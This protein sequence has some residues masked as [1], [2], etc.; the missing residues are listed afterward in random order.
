MTVAY[1]EHS[2]AVQVVRAEL[3]HLQLSESLPAV[4]LP[5]RA[6][7]E[8][9]L[10]LHLRRPRLLV[11]LRQGESSTLHVARLCMLSSADIR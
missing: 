11:R 4:L 3:H 5:R 9:H 10:L 1:S 8:V 6:P 7:H 2:P